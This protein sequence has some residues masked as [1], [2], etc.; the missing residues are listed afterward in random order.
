MDWPAGFGFCGECEQIQGLIYDFPKKYIVYLD[1]KPHV[2]HLIMLKHQKKRTKL[3][4]NFYS[5]PRE[6]A[7]LL[8]IDLLE[9]TR[10]KRKEDNFHM[11]IFDRVIE[12]HVM[13]SSRINKNPKDKYRPM[14]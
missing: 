4:R 11:S 9:W 12:I 7:L 13:T 3:Y 5:T 1:K 6:G 10:I 8:Y 14:T 2:F